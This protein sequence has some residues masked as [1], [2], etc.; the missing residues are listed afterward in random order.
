MKIKFEISISF[1]FTRRDYID[2]VIRLTGSIE[3][4][5]P[6]VEFIYVSFVQR[7]E[8]KI[9][10]Q[11]TPKKFKAF[12]LIK[13]FVC[14][15]CFHLLNLAACINQRIISISKWTHDLT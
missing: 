5:Q 12:H 2:K 6:S 9:K 4:V 8:T 1:Y 13:T 15:M 3:R 14:T 11:K 7:F 10:L